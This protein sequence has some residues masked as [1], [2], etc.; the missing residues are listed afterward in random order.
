MQATTDAAIVDIEKEIRLRYE[1]AR[2]GAPQGAA[3]TVL[4]IGEALTAV[5]T[6]SAAQPDTVLVFSIGSRKTAADFFKH[7]PPTPGELE[8]AIMAVEDDV[9]RLRAI[10]ATH[11]RLFTSDAAIREIALVSG[12]ADQPELLLSIEATE[13]SF[14]KLAA[15]AQGR[16]A[17]SAGI[18]LDAA[19]AA[20][21]LILREFMHHLQF[22]AITITA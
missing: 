4:H 2:R 22:A 18:P 15:L 10:T 11:S 16:P 19:F 14:D 5:A 21:L 7:S 12:V 8:N 13:Q 1:A 6:G 9:T 3:I 17:S 20:R